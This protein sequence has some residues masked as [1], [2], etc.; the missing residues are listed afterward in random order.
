VIDRTF[1]VGRRRENGRLVSYMGSGI[2]TF[3]NWQK[4]TGPLGTKETDHAIPNGSPAQYESALASGGGRRSIT[5]TP[6]STQAAADARALSPAGAS[7]V[8]TKASLGGGLQRLSK[9]DSRFRSEASAAA[10]LSSVSATK[11]A[12]LQ[13]LRRRHTRTRCLGSARAADSRPRRKA[14]L[15]ILHAVKRAR[16]STM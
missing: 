2:A 13:E 1:V 11:P 6:S 4:A 9:S 8:E 15:L 3:D 7:L 12:V 14:G 5:S 10:S 16:L